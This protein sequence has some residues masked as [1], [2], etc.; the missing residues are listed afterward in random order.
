MAADDTLAGILLL[1]DA[2]ND[3]IDVS[4]LLL[5]APLLRVLPAK[6][7]SHG[8]SH[9]YMKE[10]V[11]P[12]VG[13]RAVDTGI[14]NAAGEETQVTVTL[15]FLDATV[16]RDIAKAKASG[17]MNKYMAMQ[18]DKSMKRAFAHCEGQIINGT[19]NEA[20][21]FAGLADNVYV[22]DI[23]DGMVVSAGGSGGKNVY[24]IRAS[25]DGVCLLYADENIQ[26]TE[27]YRV[28]SN[29]GAYTKLVVDIDAYLGLQVSD[30]FSVARIYNLDGTSGHTLTDDLISQAISLAPTD[31]P[32]THCVMDRVSLRELQQ[33]RTATNPT[34]KPAEFP[35]TVSGPNGEIPIIVTDQIDATNTLATTTT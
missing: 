21:G 28:E 8:T 7:S 14:T 20:D 16:R 23:G 10:T 34:G 12:G 2:N 1:T 3:P 17:D 31:K 6:K 9:Q 29:S 4:D 5:G 25:L 32:F 27:P 26:M 30:V 35:S 19:G 24:L 13:F 15:A 11:A 22:D 18:A 33:S